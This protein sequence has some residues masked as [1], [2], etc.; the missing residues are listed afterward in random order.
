MCLVWKCLVVDSFSAKQHQNYSLNRGQSIYVP[1]S[2]LNSRHAGL[3]PSHV[4]VSLASSVRLPLRKEKCSTTSRAI[5]R[6]EPM[7]GDRGASTIFSPKSTSHSQNAS[8][9]LFVAAAKLTRRQRRSMRSWSGKRLKRPS[10]SASRLQP[11]RPRK[12]NVSKPNFK[13]RHGYKSRCR[14]SSGAGGDSHQ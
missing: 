1:H 8:S 12:S 3:K 6:C 14:A 11:A 9:A 2:F 7:Q 13:L 4:A 10:E 5:V